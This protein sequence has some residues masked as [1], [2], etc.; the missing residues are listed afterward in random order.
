MPCGPGVLAVPL[1]A[2]PVA[3][4]FA[5]AFAF[6]FAL[7]GLPLCFSDEDDGCLAVVPAEEGLG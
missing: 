5:F 3:V 1:A 7:V 4:A 6:A 2:M